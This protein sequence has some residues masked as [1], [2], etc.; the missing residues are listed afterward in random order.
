VGTVRKK[1]LLGWVGALAGAP[2]LAGAYRRVLSRGDGNH[3]RRL[4][5]RTRVEPAV[6]EDLRELVLK[7]NGRAAPEGRESF[8]VPLPEGISEESAYRELRALLETW[9]LSHPNV[10]AEIVTGQRQTVSDEE[11][12]GAVASRER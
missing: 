10:R 11:P 3:K 12:V 9:E 1:K 4:V 5:V 7:V 2:L 6:V 8:S